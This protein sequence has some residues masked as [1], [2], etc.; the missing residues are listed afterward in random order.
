[1]GT[2]LI[3]V[4]ATMPTNIEELLQQIID[5][6]TLVE[7]ISP[8]LHKVMDHVPQKYAFLTFIINKH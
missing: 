7:V 4:S 3:M 6:N 8:N 5:T 1:M 2:Q